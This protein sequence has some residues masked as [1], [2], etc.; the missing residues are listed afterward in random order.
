MAKITDLPAEIVAQIVKLVYASAYSTWRRKLRRYPKLAPWEYFDTCV[1][2]SYGEKLRAACPLGVYGQQWKYEEQRVIDEIDARR[3]WRFELR[4]CEK[5]EMESKRDWQFKL[6]M[7]QFEER[8]IDVFDYYPQYPLTGKSNEMS[9]SS[10]GK[11][12]KA[13]KSCPRKVFQFLP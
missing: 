8:G 4:H 10:G 12:D 2:T 5:L 13:K 11:A 7:Q 6:E 9:L 3:D 1:W